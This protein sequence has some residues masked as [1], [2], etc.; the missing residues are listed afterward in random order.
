[1]LLHLWANKLALFSCHQGA[2]PATPGPKEA[3]CAVRRLVE[4]QPPLD[5]HSRMAEAIVDGMKGTTAG[6]KK[7]EEKFDNLEKLK[8]LATCGLHAEEA[9]LLGSSTSCP[10]QIHRKRKN[11]LGCLR[12][13]GTG[14]PERHCGVGNS[15]STSV[16]VHPT[17]C[18]RERHEVWVARQQC[19]SQLSP[20]NLSLHCA[21]QLC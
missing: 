14:M 5:Q 1:M 6:D 11:S 19:L 8:I 4:T 12:R 2:P 18:R 20:G 15:V 10:Q 9:W 3:V 13:H 16:L 7:K 21:R 17:H